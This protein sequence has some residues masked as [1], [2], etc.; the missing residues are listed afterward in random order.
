[1]GDLK[2]AHLAVR[3]LG[4]GNKFPALSIES[5]PDSMDF[6]HGLIKISQN[7]LVIGHCHGMIVVRTLPFVE[8]F[9]VAVHAFSAA[10]KKSYGLR[11]NAIC[12]QSNRCLFEEI[13]GDRKNNN[14][15]CN[16]T[17]DF[18]AFHV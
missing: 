14:N 7:G 5:R 11:L 8:F 10:D 12:V 13:E 9:F 15:G 1:M 16:K 17:A 4:I 18:P 6:K 3:P 2:L